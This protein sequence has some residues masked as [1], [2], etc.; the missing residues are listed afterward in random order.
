MVAEV[1]DGGGAL[2]PGDVVHRWT[3]APNASTSEEFTSTGKRTN[4]VL[5]PSSESGTLWVGVGPSWT[6]SIS[7]EKAKFGTHSVK[8]VRN[9]S[10]P[11]NGYAVMDVHGLT[12]GQTYTLSMYMAGGT[13][14][15]IYDLKGASG[16]ASGGDRV[17]WTAGL[18]EWHRVSSGPFVPSQEF[19]T[20][21][22]LT[23]DATNFV[24]GATMY[25]DGFLTELGS[26]LGDYFDGSTAN[27]SGPALPVLDGGTATYV[28]PVAGPELVAVPTMTPVP[29]V[30]ITFT[31]I[32]AG[33]TRATVYRL[34]GDRVMK[35]RG[36]IDVAASGGFGGI[37]TEPPFNVPITYRA[38][39][40]DAAGSSLGY[41]ESSTTTVPFRGTV[42]HQPIDPERAVQV[43]LALDA[44]PSLVR[45]F[46]GEIVRPIGRPVPVYVGTGR[47]GLTGVVLNALT[48]T[49]DDD[50]AMASVFGGYE[51]M[52]LPVLCVRSS[53][54][55][56]LPGTLFVVVQQPERVPQDAQVGGTAVRWLL[57]GDEV[58]PPVENVVGALLA[59]SDIENSFTSYS[60]IENGYLTYLDLE[61]DFDLREAR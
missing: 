36:L 13:P 33:A 45:P 50:A 1:V 25:L 32:D 48:L 17:F 43:H 20:F 4:L 18:E 59:Y 11:G 10:T 58:A 46:D 15:Q 42:I 55:T 2:R 26:T 23:D 40:F 39:M 60:A 19:V 7:T 37:D 14:G 6:G 28:F 24:N 16:F 27:A 9:T 53:L 61:T 8:L 3:G 22:V 34:G 30:E 54:P 41:T 49:A 31:E 56:G 5:D 47:T 29:H 21:Y 12:P 35:V 52:Q 44:V 57:T 51:D 38:E